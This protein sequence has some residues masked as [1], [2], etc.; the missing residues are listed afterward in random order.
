MPM[1]RSL[2]L[3]LPLLAAAASPL[4]AQSVRLS[5]PRTAPMLAGIDASSAHYADVARRIW[6][7]A[8]VGYQEVKSSA[9]LQSELKSAGFTV[10][11]GVA[12]E[13]TAFV[14]E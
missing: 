12:G 8:E 10:T 1:T 5:A 2:S 4:A 9:L 7:F 13:P 11:A 6:E 14:A 3:L